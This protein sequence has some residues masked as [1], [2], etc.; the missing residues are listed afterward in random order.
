MKILITLGCGVV[1]L[2]GSIAG[3]GSYAASR[4]AAQ[5]PNRPI[6]VIVP[7]PAAAVIEALKRYE[8]AGATDLCIRLAGSDQLPQQERL[9]RDVVPAFS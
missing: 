3:N 1:L 2:C 9:I 6:R 7:G 8:E 5:Y 4:E